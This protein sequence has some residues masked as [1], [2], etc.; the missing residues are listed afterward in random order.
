[1]R[2]TLDGS[3]ERDPAVGG[4]DAVGLTAAGFA[5]HGWF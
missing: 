2:D 1:M 3:H 4:G 5:R